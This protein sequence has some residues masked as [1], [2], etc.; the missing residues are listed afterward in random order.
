MSDNG[1]SYPEHQ[2]YK[3]KELPRS[4]IGCKWIKYFNPLW[5]GNVIELLH[6]LTAC[7]LHFA[8]YYLQNNP[9]D[10]GSINWFNLIAYYSFY[11]CRKRKGFS[12]KAL[13]EQNWSHS[14]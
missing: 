3:I 12:T 10:S 13:S 1:S 14:L 7:G 9:A 4:D 8:L 11:T 2:W 5:M 6:P